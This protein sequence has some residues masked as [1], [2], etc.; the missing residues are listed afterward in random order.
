MKTYGQDGVNGFVL[1]GGEPEQFAAGY[2][3][4]WAARQAWPTM[5]T[6][7]RASAQAFQARMEAEFGDDA[8]RAMMFP[9]EAG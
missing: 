7:A 3:R 2:R 1:D 6:A 4:A 8:A 9:P 5:A